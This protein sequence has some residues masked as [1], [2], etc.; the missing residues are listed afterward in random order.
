MK[1]EGNAN[2]LLAFAVTAVGAFLVYFFTLAPTVTLEYSG[3]LAVA[4]DRLGVPSPPGYPLWTMLGWLFCRLLGFARYHGHPNPAWALGVMSAF[5]GACAC[6]LAA[7]LVARMV[8]DSTAEDR[9]RA[10]GFAACV[11][12]VTAGLVLAFSNTIW[13]ESVIVERG[14]LKMLLQT[15]A[16]TLL[17]Y[18]MR[19]PAG[20]YLPCFA[21]LVLGLGL[22]TFYPMVLMVPVFFLCVLLKDKRLFRDS[23]VVGSVVG[24][25]IVFNW[26]LASLG[27]TLSDDGSFMPKYPAI[28]RAQWM[29]W[30]TGPHNNPFWVYLAINLAAIA[31]GWIFLP[32][33]RTVA[34]SFLLAELALLAC[35]YLPLASDANPPLNWGY[36]RTWEG[37]IHCVSRGQYESMNA[38]PVFSLRYVEQLGW[39]FRSLLA[40]FSLP[41]VALA[42]VGM[43]V[44]FRRNWRWGL[45][46]LG[47]FVMFSFVVV[48]CINPMMD[49]QDSYIQRVRLIQSYG[50]LVLW[51][52]TGV[53][54]LLGIAWRSRLALVRMAAIAVVAAL[55]VLPI[56]SNACDA[57]L[58]REFGGAD[59]AGHDFGWQFGAYMLEGA[60][61]INADL[62]PG[63]EPLP[64]P[65][66]PPPCEPGAIVFGGTDP[67]R[68]VLTYMVFGAC[69]RSD[70]FVLTQ[71]ALADNTYMSGMR[72]LYGEQ[73]WIP[74]V[75][76]NN[77]A[78]R[79][80]SED[81]KAG[82]GPGNMD[83]RGGRLIV[84]GVEHVMAIN[85]ILCKMIHD[86]NKWKHDFYVEE[87]YVIPWMYP[88]MEPNGLILKLNKEELPGLSPEMVKNDMEFWAWYVRRLVSNPRFRRDPVAQKSFSKLRS[89]IAG[90][91]EYRDMREQ[92]EQAFKEAIQL[93]P[94]TP[95][96][97]FRLAGMYMRY[98]R[99]YDARVVLER[100]S[101]QDSNNQRT[102]DII[103]DIDRR[104]GLLGR[105]D[106][107]EHILA[108][109]KGEAPL[110]T[111]F[112][113]ACVY[114]DLGNK[115]AFKSIM[116]DMLKN[117]NMPPDAYF[118]AGEA[119]YEA[120]MYDEM[121]VALKMF[122]NRA[123]PDTPAHKL[124][125]TAELY[126]LG[127]GRI[128]EA[129]VALRAYLERA[130]EDVQSWHELGVIY[131]Y[132][133]RHE[134][135]VKALS[136]AMQIG[137]NT[138]RDNIRKDSRLSPF[139]SRPEYQAIFGTED[140]ASSSSPGSSPVVTDY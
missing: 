17:Y 13:S 88:Y 21:A 108:G 82:R 121:A 73:M 64:D 14:T 16:L 54:Y 132:Q 44:Q 51:L 123:S 87:S 91:Y 99:L 137:G 60:G 20:D 33:G 35:L 19:R 113:L 130:P 34:V 5:F 138:A 101:R 37:F 59:Q 83:V 36:A 18:W 126:G 127:G 81:V 49:M 74:S 15:G 135:A 56:L 76:D 92:A 110:S 24:G 109:G 66:Y 75:G 58:I 63:E 114:L 124:K 30:T 106:E 61:A 22:S 118:A 96:A 67:G 12:G 53:A 107:L 117:E 86:F 134:E 52:G 98:G 78:F 139:L 69:L 100:F 41:A 32:R 77:E 55:P 102:G 103:S 133:N 72:D 45:T 71:N 129:C 90:L 31:L 7:L 84:T 9:G 50:V 29:L 43:I 46:L 40:N 122:M 11:A 119:F 116:Q 97:S 6:G 27:A 47:A 38:S 70:V 10:A 28:A 120:K 1:P 93:C 95:E 94:T 25:L 128:Q 8:R 111:V 125:K 85:G 140:S 68:F 48:S 115:A 42:M 39:Y 131:T 104:K 80:Y 62:K 89:A 23:V 4:A 112:E 2:P 57:K 136:Q 105:K 79:I 3:S 65:A 26:L